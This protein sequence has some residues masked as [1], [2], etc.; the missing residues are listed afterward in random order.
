MKR[1]LP[2]FLQNAVELSFMGVTFLT[3]LAIAFLVP[4]LSLF[5]SDELH[6]RPL[7]VGAFFTANAI[8]G[9]VI[10]LAALIFFARYLSLV[11]DSAPAP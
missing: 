8:A 6:V 5:L 7:L 9:I 2:S 3:G 4:V 10:G 1:I 11:Y